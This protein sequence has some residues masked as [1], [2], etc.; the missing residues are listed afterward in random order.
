MSLAR[1]LLS[2]DHPAHSCAQTI[3]VPTTLAEDARAEID[4]HAPNVWH[5]T[6]S[7]PSQGHIGACRPTRRMQKAAGWADEWARLQCG[8]L[9]ATEVYGMPRRCTHCATIITLLHVPSRNACHGL[10][11][12]KRSGATITLKP[13]V[14]WPICRPLDSLWLLKSV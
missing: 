8:I 14:R 4:L 10:F 9:S 13:R 7:S 11:A 1:T 12:S 6:A 5:L 3:P 2:R